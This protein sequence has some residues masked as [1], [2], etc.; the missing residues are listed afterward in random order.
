MDLVEGSLLTLKLSPLAQIIVN[1]DSITLEIVETAIEYVETIP[2]SRLKRGITEVF[3]EVI[4]ADLKKYTGIHTVSSSLKSLLLSI[5]HRGTGV[6]ATSF[7]DEAIV[8]GLLTVIQDE[9]ESVLRD[10]EGD[11]NEMSEDEI[12]GILTYCFAM[13]EKNM[14]ADEVITLCAA[15]VRITEK[16]EKR[17]K[18]V[19]NM[20]DVAT[21]L[22][23]VC[24]DFCLFFEY[25]PSFSYSSILFFLCVGFRQ[26]AGHAKDGSPTADKNDTGESDEECA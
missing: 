25:S 14:D 13:R 20:K 10:N 21:A 22:R 16:K 1:Q 18:N 3:F 8:G 12:K 5:M 6:S 26:S 4:K 2:I 11:V 24:E 9:V 15:L 7:Y 19:G 17:V 23:C